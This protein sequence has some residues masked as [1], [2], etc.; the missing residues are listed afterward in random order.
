M[1]TR[2]TLDKLPTNI[3]N[4]IEA[5]KQRYN[6]ERFAG[7]IKPAIRSYLSAYLLG[8]RDSGVITETEKRLLYCY[9]TL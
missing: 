6:D 1:S 8:L 7:D 3:L 4:N 5:L 9:V 2:E